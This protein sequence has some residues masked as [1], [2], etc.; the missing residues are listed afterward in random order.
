MLEPSLFPESARFCYVRTRSEHSDLMNFQGLHP[1]EQSIVS[2]SVNVRKSEFG[3][4]RWCAHEAL[5]EA[6]YTGSEP[7]LRG[8]R[9]KPLW[10]NGFTGSMTHTEGFRAAVAAPT[11]KVR[12]L[13]LD[14]EP[15]EQ[16]PEGVLAMIARS[17]EIPQL[18][19]L[20][21]AG[22]PFADRLLFCAKEAT[23]K[24]W[25]PMTDRWLGFDQAEIDLR[26]DGTLI[27]YLLVRPTPVPFISGRW[28]V[29]DGYVVVATTV[30]INFP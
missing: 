8:E 28:I 24:A 26:E 22:I 21:A 9:G 4:A 17:G 20:R 1:L 25:F 29:R 14:A 11:T 15:A 16:L 19:R 18:E 6:G 27:S 7:I 30:D 5:R 12:S 10:P 23:Y 2:R 3:D 13:G